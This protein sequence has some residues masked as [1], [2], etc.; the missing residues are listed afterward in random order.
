MFGF[1]PLGLEPFGY[2]AQQEPEVP[3]GPPGAALIGVVIAT[4]MS[5]RPI[6]LQAP[7]SGAAITLTVSF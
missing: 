5:D 1:A 4:I 7:I 6:N 2:I 3:V